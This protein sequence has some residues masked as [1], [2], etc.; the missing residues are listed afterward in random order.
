M[1]WEWS[2]FTSS[3]KR[4]VGYNN[5]SLIR[6][7]MPHFLSSATVAPVLSIFIESSMLLHLPCKRKGNLAWRDTERGMLH[8]WSNWRK[9]DLQA[10]MYKSSFIQIWYKPHVIRSGHQEPEI[11]SEKGC[12][13][14]CNLPSSNISLRTKRLQ[15]CTSKT[16]IHLKNQGL[17]A[18]LL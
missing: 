18:R 9:W 16:Y 4:L 10:T 7:I 1:N 12:Q 15:F 8:I 2:I 13:V 11:I 5:K 14:M 3:L 6:H 17:T